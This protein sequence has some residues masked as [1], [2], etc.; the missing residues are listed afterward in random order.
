[1][2]VISAVRSSTLGR[3]CMALLNNTTH[4]GSATALLVFGGAHVVVELFQR[5]RVGL[6]R[7]VQPLGWKKVQEHEGLLTGWSIQGPRL[8]PDAHGD[9]LAGCL[10]PTTFASA[11]FLAAIGALGAVFPRLASVLLGHDAV[12]SSSNGACV[13]VFTQ[14]TMSYGGVWRTTG[15]SISA[16]KAS[17]ARV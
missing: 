5:C 1:M 15:V 14:G 4:L 9:P 12:N 17:Q 16:S 11:V 6:T 7:L 13:D 2:P 3:K 10:T 8:A